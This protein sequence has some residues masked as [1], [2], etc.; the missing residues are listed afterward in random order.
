MDKKEYRQ[1]LDTAEYVAPIYV[2]NDL[3]IISLLKQLKLNGNGQKQLSGRL[4]AL[5][6]IILAILKA[7]IDKPDILLLYAPLNNDVFPINNFPVGA[8]VFRKLWQ[9][10]IEVGWI[11]LFAAKRI[12]SS[13]RFSISPNSPLRVSPELRNTFAKV[14]YDPPLVLVRNKRL[15]SL[16]V[17]EM[18]QSNGQKH[19]RQK[20]EIIPISRFKE[21]G[22]LIEAQVRHINELALTHSI[23]G[24]PNGFEF[25]GFTRVFS[26]GNITR[27]GRLY[28][29]YQR[30]KKE[31]R[32]AIRLDG[33][34]VVELDV[35]ASHPFLLY[36]QYKEHHPGYLYPTD[37]YSAVGLAGVSRE[38]IKKIVM[39]CTG[40]GKIISQ[41]PKGE[42]DRGTMSKISFREFH[43][44]LRTLKTKTITQ[45]IV[46]ALPFLNHL[47]KG[48]CDWG[49]LQ[50]LEAEL[51]LE[52]TV[53]LLN[54]VIIGLPIHDS[55]LV[56]A[57]KQQITYDRLQN[58]FGRKFGEVP[59]IEIRQ[60]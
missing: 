9:R 15:E 58:I 24:I 12:G 14:K 28:A 30:L 29:D 59:V 10:C 32:L 34:P 44:I 40:Q 42:I 16:W 38:A 2:S 25:N 31:Q 50:L 35:K 22:K 60:L 54:E 18:A 36:Q 21:A 57:S 46:D 17:S 6:S 52:L 53:S 27:G 19:V 51:F 48:L 3:H 11:E 13:A 43:G 37:P 23:E 56:P 20:K 1:L 55:V 45:A 39:A 26:N 41:L 4:I 7:D 33:E 5:S 47:Q 8:H 49:T